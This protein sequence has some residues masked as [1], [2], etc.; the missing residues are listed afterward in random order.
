[1]PSPSSRQ[2]VKLLDFLDSDHHELIMDPREVAR[3]F[4]QIIDGLDAPLADPTAIPTWYMSKLAR[5]RVTVALSGEGADEI[6]GGYARQRY[7]VAL[8]RIGKWAGGC[9]RRRCFWRAGS[10]RLGSNSGCAWRRGWSVSSTG[11]GFFPAMRSGDW[12]RPHL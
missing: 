12:S 6:F 9:C 1:M 3:D 2:H 4:E 11:V 7:D 10:R 5:E 8:D